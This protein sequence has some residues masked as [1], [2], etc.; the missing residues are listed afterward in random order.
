MTIQEIVSD[1]DELREEDIYVA[2]SYA[3]DSIKQFR[4]QDETFI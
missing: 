3:A 4:L 2:L 1:Y